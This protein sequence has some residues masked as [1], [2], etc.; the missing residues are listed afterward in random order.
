MKFRQK[1]LSPL[2]NNNCT[3]C[4][5]PSIEICEDYLTPL[6]VEHELIAGIS[7]NELQ[8]LSEVLMNNIP[9]KV[10]LLI[11]IPDSVAPWT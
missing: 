3:E 6:S 1:N 4:Q 9:F 2:P 10:V 5:N 7:R 11:M 8:K